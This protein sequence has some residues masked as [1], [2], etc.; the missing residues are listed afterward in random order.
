MN[1]NISSDAAVPTATAPSGANGVQFELRLSGSADTTAT[2]SSAAS[3]AASPSCSRALLCRPA[4]FVAITAPYIAPAAATAT[5][6]PVP[7][8]SET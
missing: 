1:E 8:R 2:S 7:S 6:R 4:R 3:T 5:P